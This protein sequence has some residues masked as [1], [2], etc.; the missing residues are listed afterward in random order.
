MDVLFPKQLVDLRQDKDKKMVIT[1]L[2]SFSELLVHV[3]E[4]QVQHMPQCSHDMHEC[5]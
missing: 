4:M 2:M 1:P 5:I 3:D